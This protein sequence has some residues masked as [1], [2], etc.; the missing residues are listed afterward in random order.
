MA[1]VIPQ[2]TFALMACMALKSIMDGEVEDG[3]LKKALYWAGGI[4]GGLCLIFWIAPGAFLDFSCEA[5]S[6]YK[7]PGWYLDAL[8][9][10]RKYL[11]SADALRSLV[12]IFFAFAIILFFGKKKTAFVQIRHSGHRTPCSHWPMGSWPEIPQQGQF[13]QKTEYVPFSKTKADEAIL[14]DKGLS[15]RVLTFND[16]FNDTHISYYHKSIGGY[17]AAKLRDYQDLIDMQIQPE[18][19]YISKSF[20]NIHT[21]A[22]IDNLLPTRQYWTCWIC[23]TW[24]ITLITRQ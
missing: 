12:F 3:K 23:A 17:N 14:Q 11:V 24:F 21:E 15:Y 13:Q 22:D 6:T 20:S 1:L 8:M 5:D 10:D 9:E 7:L 4:T 19:E 18:M 2:L 16:P